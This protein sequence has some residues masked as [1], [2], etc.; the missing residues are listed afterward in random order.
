MPRVGF[1]PTVP[2]STRA[3]TVHAVDCL[4]TLTGI[5]ITRRCKNRMFITDNGPDLYV[6][7]TKQESSVRLNLKKYLIIYNKHAGLS[8]QVLVDSRICSL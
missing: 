1:E 6:F 8:V 5:A 7:Q 2:A 3:M 4:A